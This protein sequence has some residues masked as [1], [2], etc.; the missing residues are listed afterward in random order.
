MAQRRRFSAEYKREVVAIID[1]GSRWRRRRR[2]HKET[3]SMSCLRRKF[4]TCSRSFKNEGGE[5]GEK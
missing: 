4:G 5:T 3:G 2:I 1:M